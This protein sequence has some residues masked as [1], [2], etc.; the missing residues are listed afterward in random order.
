[1]FGSARS[2][3]SS[4]GSVPQYCKFGPLGATWCHIYSYAELNFLLVLDGRGAFALAIVISIS[5]IIFGDATQPPLDGANTTAADFPELLN[6]I[7][8]PLVGKYR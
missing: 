7:S 4:A 1:M 3:R 5:Y 6:L 8:F 2:E